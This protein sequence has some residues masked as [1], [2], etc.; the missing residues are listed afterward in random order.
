[1]LVPSAASA[2][3]AFHKF[4]NGQAPQA[5]VQGVA[6]DGSGNVYAVSGSTV[7]KLDSDGALQSQFGSSGSGDGQFIGPFGVALNSAG[8]QIFVTDEG[9]SRI[10]KFDGNGSFVA[11]VGTNGTGATQFQFPKGL[12]V[13]STGSVWVADSGNNQVKK[14]DSN[15]T[16]ANSLNGTSSCSSSVAFSHPQFLATDSSDNL[17][18]GDLDHARIVVCASDGVFVREWS[19]SVGSPEGIDVDASG[20]VYVA[21]ASS[22]T[23]HKFTSTGSL[24]ATFAGPGSGNGQLNAPFGLGV[25]AAGNTWVADQ[26]N[27]RLQKFDSA[28]TFVTKVA[29]STTISPT[30]RTATDVATDPLGN[31]YVVDVDEHVVEKFDETGN[32]QGEHARIQLNTPTGV[33]IQTTTGGIVVSDNVDNKL[34]RFDPAT[35]INTGTNDGT[36]TGTAFS[37]PQGVAYDALNDRYYVVDTGNS[38]I[39]RVSGDLTTSSV[40]V[41]GTGS[42]IGEFSTPLGVAVDASG[43]VYVADSGNNRVMQFND[44]GLNISNLGT[45]GSGPGQF[46]APSNVAVEPT[47][48]IVVTDTG[49]NRLQRILTP[50]NANMI[51]LEQFG[52]AGSG[53]LGQLNAPA[54]VAVDARGIGYVVDTGNKRV[55]RYGLP[56]GLNPIAPKRILDTRFGTGAPTGPIGPNATLNVD[57]TDTF[58]SGVPATGVAAVILNV[59]A[60]GPSQ[61]GWLTLF[62]AGATLPA[63]SNLNFTAGQTVPNLVVVKVGTGGNVSINN[64]GTPTNPQPAAGP[65]HVIADVVGWYS[66]GSTLSGTAPASEFVGVAPVRVLDTRIG[67][68]APTGP[69]APN[70]TLALDVGTVLPAECVGATTAVLNVTAT[71]PTQGGWLT[72]F[73]ADATLPN[74]SNLNFGPGQTVPNLVTVKLGA[75]GG[76]SGKVNIENTDVPSGPHPA[77]GTVHAIADLTGCYKPPTPGAGY[78]TT[79]APVRILDTRFGTGV[80]G[81]SHNPVSPNGAI[82]VDPQVASP[83]LPPV[84]QYS[85]VIVNVTATGPTQDGW[86]TVYPSGGALPNASNLNFTAGQTVPNLVKIKVGADGKF[87]IENTDVPTL[88]HPASGTVHV[89]VDIVGYYQ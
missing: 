3:P 78:A 79:F 2:T 44:A 13:D 45:A 4:W 26:T 64:T 50:Q 18:I 51:F 58:G 73:P 53:T 34:K 21:D 60:T 14:F 89:I 6:V 31:T 43:N 85:G 71:A 83:S 27:A 47:G 30:F 33:A 7:F 8:T 39:V 17:Y 88:P 36:G 16:Y 74:T 9:N 56:G 77:S 72:V 87:T 20:N 75:G 66:D 69:I 24:L 19:T 22:S 23:I 86:L 25:D 57:V 41:A 48:N 70:G 35:D 61:G 76:N 80:V 59:T 55:Q 82:T 32:F 52:T 29:G 5:G 37:N 38:R 65:V 67:T 1:M 62:P 68:G 40:F 15:L 12:A 28:G 46:N 81:G 42:G 63:A 49:N 11:Q 10:E 54:G 84:G